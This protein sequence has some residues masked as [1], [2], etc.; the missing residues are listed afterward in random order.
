VLIGTV[1]A[2]TPELFKLP[3]RTAARRSGVIIAPE[4]AFLT[5]R[6]IRTMACAG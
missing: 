5:L 3:A 1:S 2:R 4:D 6:G